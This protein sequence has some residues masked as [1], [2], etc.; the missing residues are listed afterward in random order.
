MRIILRWFL[1]ALAL[2]ATVWLGELL[3]L[4]LKL[5]RPI[6]ALGAVI[7][8][9]LLN[10]LVRPLLKILTIPLSCLTLGLSSLFINIFLFWLAGS[11]GISGLQV[12]GF[13]AALFGSVLFSFLSALANQLAKQPT[14]D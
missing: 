2:Y 11:I 4:G 9:A 6:S 7:I 1:N 14:K 13:W 3:G 8:L 5:T 12:H 10:S